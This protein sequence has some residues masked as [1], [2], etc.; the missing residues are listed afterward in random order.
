MKNESLK[1]TVSETLN[2]IK[3]PETASQVSGQKGIGLETPA[4]AGQALELIKRPECRKR[5]L[6][7]G[8]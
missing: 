4:K 2:L 8:G 1:T 7:T 5:T 6:R 3:S